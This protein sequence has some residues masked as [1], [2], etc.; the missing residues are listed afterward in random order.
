MAATASLCAALLGFTVWTLVGWP[1]KRSTEAR[2]PRTR[3]DRVSGDGTVIPPPA[4]RPSGRGGSDKGSPDHASAATDGGKPKKD[5]GDPARTLDT[6]PTSGEPGPRHQRLLRAT[7]G[8]AV[9]RRLVGEPCYVRVRFQSMPGLELGDLGSSPIRYGLFVRHEDDAD[10]RR[11]VGRNEARREHGALVVGGATPVVPQELVLCLSHVVDSGPPGEVEFVATPW[12][13]VPR[14]EYPLSRPGTYTVRYEARLQLEGGG[15]L[16][17]D[18]GTC[19]VRTREPSHPL[20]RAALDELLTT[21]ALTVPWKAVTERSSGRARPS[22]AYVQWLE[23][24]VERH[25]GSV[26]VPYAV[27]RLV[28]ALE[29]RYD[30]DGALHLLERSERVLRRTL[31]EY[32]DSTE[33]ARLLYLLGENLRKGRPD[34]D[35]RPDG[36]S[37]ALEVFERLVQDYPDSE[38]AGEAKEKIAK[39]RAHLER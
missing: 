12:G 7:I 39:L 32:I 31:H 4:A 15:E 29:L 25:W 33:R 34:S 27:T 37:E 16:T 17:I 22:G 5:G 30:P 6:S 1:E 24:F 2:P 36:R 28:A 8:P 19:E 3:H 35:P 38:W 20:D 26:Y 23:G 9:Q 18:A 11:V 14:R 13:K 10:W 21:H